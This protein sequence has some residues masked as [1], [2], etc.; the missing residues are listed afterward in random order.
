MVIMDARNKRDI[1]PVIVGV[2]GSASGAAAIEYGAWE[3][4][5][6]HAALLL[7]HGLLD[8]MPYPSYG[9]VPHVPI[10]NVVRAEA[11]TM[12]EQAEHR[13]RS[14]HPGLTV[15]STLVAGGGAST[16]VELSRTAQ[17][18]VVGARGAGGFAELRLGSVSA[19]VTMHAHAPVVVVRE[20]PATSAG[21]P[22]VVG[23]DG[24]PAADEALAFAYEEAVARGVA[25]RP[26]YAWW[27]LPL[28]NLGPTNPL[29]YEPQVAQDEANRMLAEVLAGWRQKYP[30]VVVEER[31]VHDLNPAWALIESSRDAGLL[32][33]G[34]RGRGGFASLLL[35]SVG[36]SVVAHA[37][38]SVAVIHEPR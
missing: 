3:A 32:V 22:V 28:R 8:R 26:V 5:H 13:T 4:R 33:V 11:R 20:D 14:T 15:R 37:S 21:R 38:C 6:R 35:G 12:V 29:T 30:D 36:Q 23:I 27:T 31:A 19:Q 18:V 10:E 17:L 2:D 16:L 25:V 34:S 9:W 24:S 1:G 7:V